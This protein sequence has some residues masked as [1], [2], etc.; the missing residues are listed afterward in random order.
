MNSTSQVVQKYCHLVHG[1]YHQLGQGDVPGNRDVF[2]FALPIQGWLERIPHIKKI[3]KKVICMTVCE[4]ETV[5]PDYG[6]LFD[7]FDFILTPSVFCQKVFERQFPDKRFEV[8]RHHV[9]LMKPPKTPVL[10]VPSDHYVFYHIGNI[11]DQRKNVKKIIE[12]FIRLQLPKSLLVL[13]ATCARPVEWKVRQRRTRSVLLLADAR[14][15][16]YRVSSSS[17]VLSVMKPSEVFMM[18]VIVT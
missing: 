6:L 7:L 4:T 3:S 11:M 12:A 1:E 14:C 8:L 5:H 2:M 10:E 17:M 15:R 16:R 9:T 13:K 18:C